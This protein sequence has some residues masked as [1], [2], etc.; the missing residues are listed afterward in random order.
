MSPLLRCLSVVVLTIFA[1]LFAFD[2]A[3]SSVSAEAKSIVHKERQVFHATKELCSVFQRDPKL[4]AHSH[5]CD[6]VL[7]TETIY[8][9]STSPAGV[10]ACPT[11]TVSHTATFYGY[12]LIWGATM[13]TTFRY[14]GNCGRPRLCLQTHNQIRIEAMVT[15]AKKLTARFS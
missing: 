5:T 15:I 11:G 6:I 13:R 10:T 3:T 1:L 8:T 2:G 9:P 7:E 14:P 4:A 12:L